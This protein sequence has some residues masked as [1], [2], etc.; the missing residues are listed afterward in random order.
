LPHGDH[1]RRGEKHADLPEVD[2][3]AVVVVPRGPQ[4]DQLYLP[5]EGFHLRAQ[6][7]RL[8][9]LH[10]QLVQAETVPHLGQLLRSWLEQSQ[11]HEAPLA[12]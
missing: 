5:V 12:A 11:P 3:L 9:V 7:E 4:D 6:M 10:G 2:L 1:E 8:G